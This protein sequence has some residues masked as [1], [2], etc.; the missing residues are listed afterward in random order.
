MLF[1]GLSKNASEFKAKL[2]RF[3]AA[4]AHQL[5]LEPVFQVTVGLS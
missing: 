4:A 5:A 3:L 2:A 1:F